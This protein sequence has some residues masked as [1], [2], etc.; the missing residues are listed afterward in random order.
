M[1]RSARTRRTQPSPAPPQPA[2]RSFDPAE[3][4]AALVYLGPVVADVRAAF[5]RVTRLRRLL[6]RARLEEG[7]ARRRRLTDA[8]QH[9][10][11]ALAGLVDEVQAVGVQLRD[12]EAGALAFPSAH[13]GVPEGGY[14]SWIP[15]EDTVGHAHG[16]D[17]PTEARRPLRQKARNRAA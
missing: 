3:A 15:G 14:L 8:H 17:E 11:N 5:R 6:D 9:Q 2:G 7:S 13:G 12:F 1:P 10:M 4:Q 16:P